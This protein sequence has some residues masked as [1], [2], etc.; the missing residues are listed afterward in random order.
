[1]SIDRCQIRSIS[2]IT[3]GGGAIGGSGATSRGGGVG[4]GNLVVGVDELPLAGDA[5]DEL[6]ENH[7]S[8][9]RREDLGRS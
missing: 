6:R 7:E 8:P 4:V 2:K 5:E 3:D 1:M 9:N